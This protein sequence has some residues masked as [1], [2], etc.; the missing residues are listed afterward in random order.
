MTEH[1]K[2]KQDGAGKLALENRV[3]VL[4]DAAAFT[5]VIEEIKLEDSRLRGSWGERVYRILLKA[6]N[7]AQSGTWTT[8][9]VQS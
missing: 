6:E 8:R 4:Y 5:P 3:Q 9:I 2:V 1:I 7:P